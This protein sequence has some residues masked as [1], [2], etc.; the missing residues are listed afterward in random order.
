M[1]VIERSDQV[2]S[3][4]ADVDVELIVWIAVGEIETKERVVAGVAVAGGDVGYAGADGRALGERERVG[5]RGKDG[6]VVVHV[7]DCDV[8]S[9]GRVSGSRIRAA[10]ASHYR[11]V[12]A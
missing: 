2:D 6:S 5:G 9:N 7:E 11:E 12:V 10:V 4:G 1:F 8:E 3:T